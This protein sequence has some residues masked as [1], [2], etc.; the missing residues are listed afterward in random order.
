MDE[1]QA[2][3][4]QRVLDENDLDAQHMLDVLVQTLTGRHVDCELLKLGRRIQAQPRPNSLVAAMDALHEG[5]GRNAQ[6]DPEMAKVQNLVFQMLGECQFA[7][8]AAA[9]I[10]GDD[11]EPPPM[12]LVT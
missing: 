7:A 5:R 2:A 6:R 8:E 12:R 3:I 4:V 11:D 10:G 1:Q 9:G